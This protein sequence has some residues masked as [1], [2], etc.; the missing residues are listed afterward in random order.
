MDPAGGPAL[1]PAVALSQ[2]Q[3]GQER[4]VGQLLAPGG[5]GDLGVPLPQARRRSSRVAASIAAST[6][7]SLG[8][9]PRGEGRVLAVVLVAVL[10]VVVLVMRPSFR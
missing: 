10:V 8:C 9:R 3:L 2:Q 5:V 4:P 1:F 6:A 7:C